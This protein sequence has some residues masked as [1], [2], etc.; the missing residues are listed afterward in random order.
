[1]HQ[2]QRGVA[3]ARLGDL[4][5]HVDVPSVGRTADAQQ[6]GGDAVQFGVEQGERAAGVA[7][8]GDDARAGGGLQDHGLCAGA[9]RG[10]EVHVVGGKGNVGVAGGDGVLNPQQA[11][12]AVGGDRDGPARGGDSAD[13]VDA[14]DEQVA[15]VGEA[16]GVGRRG[17]AQVGHRVGGGRQV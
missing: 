12:G 14:V 3:A 7:A 8:Q 17:T 10:L 5:R 2:G 15:V 13:A 16:E 11:A 4:S 9:D 1:G 6:A